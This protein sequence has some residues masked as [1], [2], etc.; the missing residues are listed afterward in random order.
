MIEDRLLLAAALAQ[1]YDQRPEILAAAR[2]YETSLLVPRYLEQMVA[3]GVEVG[4]EE[5]ESYYLEH[6]RQFN[7]PPRIR[8]GQITVAEEPEAQEIAGLL[9]GGTELAWLARRHSIDRFRDQGGDRGWVDPRSSA[10]DD[11][12]LA[13]SVG[14]VLDPVG[15]P[16]N[17]VVLTVTARREQEPYSFDEVSG[18]VRN[19]VFSRKMRAAIEGLMA[20]MRDRSEIEIESELLATVR[21]GGA[22]TR[23]S[24]DESGGHG[25]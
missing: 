9:R 4:A 17:Y 12:L 18:N 25:H 13:A 1:G 2:A 11:R 20:T 5:M 7:R 21:L 6:R 8:L 24:E 22:M 3:P 14:D 23:R 10:F 15:V 19:A 16:G